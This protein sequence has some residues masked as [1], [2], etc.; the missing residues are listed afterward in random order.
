MEPVVL[1]RDSRIAFGS[2]LVGGRHAVFGPSACSD[3]TMVIMRAEGLRGLVVGC[4]AYPPTC[5][6]PLSTR[7]DPCF[8]KILLYQLDCPYLISTSHLPLVTV[9]PRRIIFIFGCINHLIQE[10]GSHA[11]IAW[12]SCRRLICGNSGDCHKCVPG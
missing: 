6:C 8:F 5:R 11:R 3:G 1:E 2:I 12:F 10:V 9:H 7:I 4:S